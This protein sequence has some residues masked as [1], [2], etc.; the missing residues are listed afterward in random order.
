MKLKIPDYIS[1]IKPYVPG[2]PMEAVQREYGIENSVKLA[3]NENPLGPS[4]MAVEAMR[5]VLD[6]VHRYPDAGGHHLTRAIA[7][8]FHIDPAGI[9]RW[10]M[11]PMIS[12]LC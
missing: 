3:S 4:P 10:V 12:S 8:Q 6:D 11:D 2:K 9:V 7:E 1:T 5:Q